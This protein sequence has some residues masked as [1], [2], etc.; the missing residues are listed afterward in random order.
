[1]VTKR[2]TKMIS[3]PQG[4]RLN[5]SFCEAFASLGGLLSLL[6]LF[7]LVFVTSTRLL[8]FVVSELFD[9]ESSHDSLTGLG[10]GENTTISSGHGSLRGSHSLQVVWPGN[11]DTLH[12]I[13]LGVFL[14]KMQN[15]F[16]TWGLDGL[17]I[18]APC[19]V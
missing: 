11:L 5:I 10:G 17:E 8:L 3:G 14:N 15:K 7:L 16:T 1:M 4:M 13:N 18:V 19:S 6:L 9:E 12:S 2:E